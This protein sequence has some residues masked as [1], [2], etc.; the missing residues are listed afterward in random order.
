M[1]ERRGWWRPMARLATEKEASVY[2]GLDLATFRIC[3]EGGRLPKPLVDCGKFDLKA[4]DAALDCLSGLGSSSDALDLWLRQDW[5]KIGMRVRLKGINHATKRLADGNIKHYWYAWRGGPL[6]QGEPGTPEF[7]ASY[8]EAVARKVTAPE[9]VLS[10]LIGKFK[11]SPKFENLARRTKDDYRKQWKLICRDFGDL[12]LKALGD[13]RVRGVFKD[14]RDQIAKRSLRQ[15]DAAW[16][17]LAR[18]LSWALDRRKISVNP[19]ERGGR[20]YRGTR[21]DK[22]WT[23]EQEASF[24]AVGSEPLRRAY[25]LAIWTGQRQGDLLRLPWSAWDQMPLPKAPH[26]RIRLTQRK[27]G[28]GVEITVSAPLADMLDATPRISPLIL[29]NSDGKPWTSNGFSSSWRK[30]CKRAGIAGITFNDLR[31]TFV[32]RAA[33]SGATEAEIAS[34]TG[35]SIG[36]VRSILDRHY[37]HRDPALGE[38]LMEKLE[39]EQI[40]QTGRQT[41][42]I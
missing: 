39:R 21:A 20:L 42:L 16:I 41:A 13:P 40:F 12:P 2:I 33:I 11:G 22:V 29:L 15:A 35:H 26:G 8:N 36:Q 1:S 25:V 23:L 32:T 5:G 19:C 17:A 34:A 14:W 37:L 38:N 24:L 28:V 18:V 3:V 27:T 30:A 4:I 7:I 9:G 31:G 6:L 10:A